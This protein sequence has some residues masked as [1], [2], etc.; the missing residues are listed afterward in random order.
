MH[1]IILYA[2]GC[3]DC[4]TSFA[5]NIAGASGTEVTHSCEPPHVGAENQIQV[6]WKSRS[7]L[8]SESSVRFF[9][10]PLHWI[11]VWISRGS[12]SFSLSLF[13][14]SFCFSTEINYNWKKL[15]PNSAW[16]DSSTLRER[17]AC[18]D[19]NRCTIPCKD[20]WFHFQGADL[21]W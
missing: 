18:R 13:A 7:A 2:R 9:S 20:E 6:V 21:L 14:N 15:F 5:T 17:L 10:L 11:S 4:L 19:P 16:G 12:H 3:F 1:N 8:N